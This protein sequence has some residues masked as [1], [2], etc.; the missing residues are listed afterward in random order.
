MARSKRKDRRQRRLSFPISIGLFFFF[1]VFIAVVVAG[2]WALLQTTRLDTLH[3]RATLELGAVLTSL[4]ARLDATLRSSES[5]ITAAAEALEQHTEVDPEALR[6]AVAPIMRACPAVVTIQLLRPEA[7]WEITRDGDTWL[8]RRDAGAGEPEGT[9]WERW[10][11][12]ATEP[13]SDQPGDPW[14]AWE[15]NAPAG[16][17]LRWA[18]L[19][20]DRPKGDVALIAE[21]GLGALHGILR[22]YVEVGA[23]KGALPDAVGWMAAMENGQVLATQGDMHLKPGT[24]IKELKPPVHSPLASAYRRSPGAVPLKDVYVHLMGETPWWFQQRDYSLGKSTRL[25]LLAGAPES[26]LLVD[27]ARLRRRLLAAAG[28]ALFF[29][30]AMS[31]MLGRVFGRPMRDFARRARRVDLLERSLGGRPFSRWREVD[32]IYQTLDEISAE[33]AARVHSRELPVIVMAEPS[34]RKGMSTTDAM[35]VHATSSSP[36]LPVEEAPEEDQ[37]PEVPEAYLQA[38]GSTRRR[39]RKLA[40][41]FEAQRRTALALEQKSDEEALQWART[42]D[43]AARLAVLLAEQGQEFEGFA[44]ASAELVCTTLE[45]TRCIVWTTEGKREIRALLPTAQHVRAGTEASET[46]APRLS[47]EV[48]TLLC[49]ALEQ[50]PSFAVRDAAL[51]P[52]TAPYASQV[53]WEPPPAGVLCATVRTHE[54]IV[55]AIFVERASTAA[56]P[57]AAEALAC[58]GAT[59]LSAAWELSRRPEVPRE[60]E[61]EPMDEPEDDEYTEPPLYRQLL[62]AQ[63]GAVL[64]LD[65]QGKVTFVNAAAE[66]L[67][68]RLAHEWPGTHFNSLSASGYGPRDAQA[69][70]RVLTGEDRV[71]ID[72]EHVTALGSTALRL[73][74]APLEDEEGEVTG[75]VVLAVDIRDIKDH[76]GELKRS[77]ARFRGYVEGLPGVVFSVD[78][79]GCI[80]YVSP[81]VQKIYGYTAVELTGVPA[82]RLAADD[83]RAERDR[84]ALAELLQRGECDGYDTTHRTKDGRE[85][86]VTIYASVRR[87]S[88]GL[89]AGAT[90]VAMPHKRQPQEDGA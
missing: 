11:S 7:S 59:A 23:L 40:E 61:P 65:A 79:I 87:D 28:V 82:G 33:V 19:D 34:R 44:Q 31:W 3:A 70:Q 14:P 9:V 20:T 80:N 16:E 60:P 47:R 24:A 68:G 52:R 17:N 86:G 78:T 35:L 85:F 74:F 12:H 38:I 64:A 5:A 54:G 41:E 51:D 66:K 1:T 21:R 29:A 62:E 56:W 50:C 49:S 13:L 67:Y 73:T 69:L 8:T 53:P 46:P 6:T 90:G 4:E 77:E 72:T 2:L 27:D 81:S 75:A 84:D 55:G 57:A 37:L 43:A 36:A 30:L 15:H 39:L 76:T 83:S 32:G 48:H 45:A 63:R 22:A 18:G 42:R 58:I 89:I 25:T 88:E 71:D 26:S 10:D